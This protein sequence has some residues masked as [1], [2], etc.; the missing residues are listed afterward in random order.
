M[1]GMHLSGSGAYMNY[2]V[3]QSLFPWFKMTYWSRPLNQSQAH[4]IWSLLCLQVP[5]L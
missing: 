3:K 4:Y 2:L 1:A 5:K